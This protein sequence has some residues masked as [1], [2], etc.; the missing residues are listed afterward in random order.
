MAINSIQALDSISTLNTTNFDII[1]ASKL[2][3]SDTLDVNSSVF[4]E[5]LTVVDSSIKKSDSLAEQY[6]KGEDVAVHDVMISMGK[7]KTELQLLIEV[8]NKL[9]EAYQEVSKIQ[10]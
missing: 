4:A 5:K 3:L 6:I 10:L 9:L 8:R 2:S 1:G 7:A